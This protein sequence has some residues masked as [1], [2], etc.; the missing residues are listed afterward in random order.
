MT[1]LEI[2]LWILAAWPLCLLSGHR[3]N[4]YVL[5][6]VGFVYLSFAS[7]ASMLLLLLVS[8]EAIA[9]NIWLCEKSRQ[10]AYRKYAHYFLFLNLFFVDLN[11]LLFIKPL[12][13]FAISFGVVRIFM[14]ARAT[15]NDRNRPPRSDLHWIIVGAFYLPALAVGPVFSATTLRDQN[16]RAARTV[17]SLR[18][19]RLLVQ[20]LVL[21]IFIVAWAQFMVETLGGWAGDASMI[22]SVLLQY[23]AVPIL[24]FLSLFCS[25]W[26]QSLIAEQTSKFF[27]YTLPQNFDQP[28]RA[29]SFKEF[30]RRWHRSMADF[31][32]KFVFLPLT[33]SGV[34]P[35]LATILAFLF[36]GLW[37]N[38]SVGY[39]LWGLAHGVLLVM[40]PDE[41]GSRD[42]NSFLYGRIAH[43]II[44]M[45]VIY[46]SYVA[47]YSF[48]SEIKF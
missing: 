41:N 9:L 18:D 43:V 1:S 25:F 10:N 3:F 34:S 35:R 30:W 4:A 46:L 7:P 42:K 37:H 20:G 44:P 45:T 47:N 2:F 15:L 19:H 17:T 16:S 48:L 11:H 40:W 29:R 38:L 5:C 27:G 33:L 32:M 31:V 21:A 13:A 14:T 23:L 26:G 22:E 28:W 12:E 8:F 24:L 6:A 39:A 36:M